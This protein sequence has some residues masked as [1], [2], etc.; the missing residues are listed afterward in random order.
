MLIYTVLYIGMNLLQ[1]P[2][3]LAYRGHLSF[4]FSA[5]REQCT[6]CHTRKFPQTCSLSEVVLLVVRY[7]VVDGKAV[8]VS[9]RGFHFHLGREPI[10]L[11]GK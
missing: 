4:M 3:S 5:V 2:Y 10:V 9:L 6:G 11:E 1:P 7:P 8:G